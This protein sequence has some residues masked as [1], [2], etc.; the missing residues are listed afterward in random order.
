MLPPALLIRLLLPLTIVAIQAGLPA[1]APGQDLYLRSVTFRGARPDLDS[2]LLLWETNARLKFPPVHNNLAYNATTPNF[3]PVPLRATDFTWEPP[4][5]VKAEALWTNP[6]HQ[7]SWRVM[8]PDGSNPSFT[9][10]LLL[11]EVR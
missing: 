5:P 4:S 2:F 3:L 8:R 6:L 1:V 9:E 11:F 7:L 10:A